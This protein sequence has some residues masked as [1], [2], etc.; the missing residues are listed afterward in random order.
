MTL[1]RQQEELDDMMSQVHVC[2]ESSHGEQVQLEALQYNEFIDKL[3]EMNFKVGVIKQAPL[4]MQKM[5]DYNVMVIGSPKDHV[6]STDEIDQIKQYVHNG[7]GL[8]LLSDQGSD[9]VNNNNLS[10][11]AMT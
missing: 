7:G 1:T 4:T 3:L 8:L 2:I 5:A 6:F 11:L 10:T 9:A